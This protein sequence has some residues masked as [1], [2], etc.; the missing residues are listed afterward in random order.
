MLPPVLYVSWVMLDD[1][2]PQSLVVNVGIN[3]G[4]SNAFMS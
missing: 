2:L 1:F 4:S 3:F